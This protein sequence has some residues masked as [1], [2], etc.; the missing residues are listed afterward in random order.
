MILFRNARHMIGNYNLKYDAYWEF[1]TF[2]A[3]GG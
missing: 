3:K 1:V 2:R